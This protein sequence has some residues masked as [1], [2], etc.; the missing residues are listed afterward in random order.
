ME[1]TYQVLEYIKENFKCLIVQ[2]K[3]S[4]NLHWHI[5]WEGNKSPATHR[6]YINSHFNLKAK[7]ISVKVMRDLNKSLLYLSKEYD[8]TKIKPIFNNLVEDLDDRFKAI[9][10]EFVASNKLTFT[11]KLVLNY[12]KTSSLIPREQRSHVLHY[13]VSSYTEHNKGFDY[14]ICNRWFNVIYSKYYDRYVIAETLLGKLERENNYF[15]Y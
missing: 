9:K 2:E 15:S 3:A 10:Q 12:V 13:I 7:Q 6:N 8:H 5:L 4:E 14:Q 1:V 11:E